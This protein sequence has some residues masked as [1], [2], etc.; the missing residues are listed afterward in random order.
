MK[1]MVKALHDAGIGEAMDVVY[2]HTAAN[3]DES[4]F[5]LTAPGYFITVTVPTAAIAMRPVA[6]TKLPPSASRCATS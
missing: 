6:V 1:Q 5:S 4:N 2:N 3:D